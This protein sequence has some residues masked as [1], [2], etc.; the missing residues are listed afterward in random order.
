MTPRW[1]LLLISLTLGIA[2]L[3]G[4][5]L[6]ETT[7]ELDRAERAVAAGVVREQ[8][9]V[10]VADSL[11]GQYR[12]D[13]VRLRS[14]RTRWDT[15]RAGIDT[16]HDTVTVPVEVVREV[17]AVADST[18]KACTMALR[19][20]ERRIAAAESV[21]VAVRVQRDAWQ[22]AL[23]ATERRGRWEKLL[24]LGAGVLGGRLLR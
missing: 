17:V 12:A 16:L 9:A 22:S 6:A 15:V 20:C 8:R 10:Y 24:W 4:W 13:T 7:A 19:T 21:T 11:R 1:A 18:V 14:W 5:R 3:T 23:T 2:G